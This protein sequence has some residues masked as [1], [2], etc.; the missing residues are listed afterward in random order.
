MLAFKFNA[1]AAE[2]NPS[3]VVV[4]Q[5]WAAPDKEVGGPILDSPLMVWVLLLLTAQIE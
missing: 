5:Q 2:F 4:I 1:H 3:Y